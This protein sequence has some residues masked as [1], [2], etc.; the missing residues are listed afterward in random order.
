MVWGAWYSGVKWH[1]PLSVE[2]LKTIF[3]IAV[4][5][6]LFCFTVIV[7]AVFAFI[8]FRIYG[9]YRS[10]AKRNEVLEAE[11]RENASLASIASTLKQDKAQLEAEIYVSVS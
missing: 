11:A 10:L 3:E 8:L 5:L 4:P 7:A 2:W 1:S 9:S 6:W